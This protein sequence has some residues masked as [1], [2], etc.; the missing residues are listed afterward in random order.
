MFR[1]NGDAEWTPT[2]CFT[3]TE[4]LPTDIPA[5]NYSPW[6]SPRIHFTQKV[7]CVRQ[8]TDREVDEPG[9]SS[10]EAISDGFIDGSL[11]IDHDKLKWRRNGKTVLSKE[12]KSDEDRVEAL[13][14]YFGIELDVEDREAILG[15]IAAIPLRES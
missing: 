8:T 12:F 6:L 14:K 2:Y 1:P 7:V 10:E 3:E 15:T 5:L 11:I 9:L 13:K 4:I